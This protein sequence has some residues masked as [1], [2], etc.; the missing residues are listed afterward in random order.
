MSNINS[1]S[2]LLEFNGKAIFYRDPLF[3]N[4]IEESIYVGDLGEEQCRMLAVEVTDVK[5]DGFIVG[6]I[7]YALLKSKKVDLHCFPSAFDPKRLTEVKPEY[8]DVYFK[9][10]F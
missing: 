1:R 7:W 6:L 2:K 8:F 3:F 10:E 5:D 9:G 4:E